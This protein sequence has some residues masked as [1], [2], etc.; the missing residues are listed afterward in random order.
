MV[1]TPTEQRNKP[2]INYVQANDMQLR[3]W[4]AGQALASA[5]IMT[6]QGWSIEQV[7]AECYVYA[8]AMM[9]ERA[10]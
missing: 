7:A 10:K 2:R 8:D 3:D 5:Q 9:A 1:Q 4:F 6:L